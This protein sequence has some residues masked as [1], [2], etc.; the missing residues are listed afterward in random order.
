MA[1]AGTA[2]RTKYPRRIRTKP[3]AIHPADARLI[4]RGLNTW[5]GFRNFTGLRTRALV[6]LAWSSALRARECLAL[7]IEQIR[8]TSYKAL[9][10][11][12]RPYIR[13]DQ[14]KMGAEGRF[15]I[16][17]RAVM[18]LRAYLIEARRRRWI[19][20]WE[21]PLFIGAKKWRGGGHDRLGYHSSNCAWNDFIDTLR[22]P[23]IYRF[24]DIRHDSIT[25]YCVEVNGDAFAVQRFG[26]F[27][28]L[29]TAV[30][31]VHESIDI[32]DAAKRAA[33]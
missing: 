30:R 1:K 27:R 15:L 19:A 10:I 7:D 18:A 5:A 33:I 17:P 16:S 12:E 23:E 11:R 8:D 31:Y 29:N 21:G 13:T 9:R 6:F 28:D 32:L 2:T 4:I 14:A 26:R 24:H 25:R 22:L 20:S 3:R